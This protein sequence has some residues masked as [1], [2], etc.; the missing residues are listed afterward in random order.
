MTM[1]V[2]NYPAEPVPSVSI[3]SS[4]YDLMGYANL[5]SLVASIERQ[6]RHDLELVVVIEKESRG[7]GQLKE[8]L[9]NTASFPITIIYSSQILGISKSR[10]LGASHSRGRIVSFVDDDA[11][12]LGNWAGELVNTFS[13]H[14]GAIGVTGPSLPDWE[15]TQDRWFPQELYWAIGCSAWKG[16]EEEGESDYAWGVN[17]SFKREVFSECTFRDAFTPGAKAAGK[18]GPVG[19]DVEFSL[20]AKR[21]CGGTIIFNPN[22]KVLHKVPTYKTSALFIRK[23]AYWQG[24]SDARFKEINGAH[25]ARSATELHAL[26]GTIVNFLPRTTRELFSNPWVARRRCSTMVQALTFFGVGYAAYLLRR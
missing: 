8:Y 23:Y 16:L 25:S 20:R 5:K 21:S 12:L 2:L 24:F 19:D 1:D 7:L 4:I 11:Q 22:L 18:S 13:R 17:M 3:V 9:H 14:P 26:K 15:K 6:P 10:N